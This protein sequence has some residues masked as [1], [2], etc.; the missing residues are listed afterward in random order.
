MFICEKYF[1]EPSVGLSLWGLMGLCV[2]AALG[3]PETSFSTSAAA[4]VI[5][6]ELHGSGA[7]V[8]A[9]LH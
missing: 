6:T 4:L 3:D 9:A 2:S 7:E 8:W 5:G 1:S